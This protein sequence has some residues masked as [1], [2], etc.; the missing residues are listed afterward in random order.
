MA[1][2]VGSARAANVASSFRSYLTTRLSIG[3]LQG[4][5]RENAM[6]SRNASVPP[7]KKR[8]HARQSTT[9]TQSFGDLR[10]WLISRPQ[11]RRRVDEHRGDQVCINHADAEAVQTASFNRLV[12]AQSRRLNAKSPARS[13]AWTGHAEVLSLKPL[14]A[15]LCQ[16]AP[17]GNSFAAA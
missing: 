12:A 7:A 9:A 16:P 3:R 11:K 5:S 1:R 15:L 6:K 13:R 4:M 10:K 8:A 14:H 2:L 17:Q